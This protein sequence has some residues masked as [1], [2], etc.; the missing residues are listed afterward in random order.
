MI[1]VIFADNDGA[2]RS[3]RGNCVQPVMG[4][5]SAMTLEN[6]R[7]NAIYTAVMEVY[8]YEYE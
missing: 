7:N 4:G 6:A 8:C 3:I 2:A 1:I 5:A